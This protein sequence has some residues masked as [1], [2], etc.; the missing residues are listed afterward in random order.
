MVRRSRL[1]GMVN[2]PE[3]GEAVWLT[4]EE[5]GQWYAF[6]CVLTLLPA[7][8]ESQLQRDAGIGH[9][10]YLVLAALSMSPERTLRMSELA[11]FVG[12]TL[13]RLSNAVS[14]F[15][16]RGWVARRPDPGDGRYTLATLTP[17]GLA[18]VEA[19][20]PGHVA[21]V[22][23]LVFSPLTIAQRRHLARASQRILEALQAPCATG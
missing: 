13:S 2:T 19:A 1:M 7:A 10:D 21:E 5:R 15:E 20:A 16:T 6:A 23:R 11:D 17:A 22:R 9:F 18:K 12:S 14:R 8:L 4:D 3:S